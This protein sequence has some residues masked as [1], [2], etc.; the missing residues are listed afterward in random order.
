MNASNNIWLPQGMPCA[1]VIK[2]NT[3]VLSRWQECK[4]EKH[5]LLLNLMPQKEVT[6]LD[7]ARTLQACALSVQ[8]LPM[9]IKGQTY[10]TT[11]LEYMNA[12]YLNFE[13]YEPY[14][15]DHLIITGA[16]L[17]QMPFEQV[18][19]WSQLCNI[20]NW[21]DKHVKHTL[22]ICWGA[23]AGLYKHYGIPKYGLTDKMFG[24]FNQDILVHNSPLMYNMQ[25]TFKM[26]NSRHTEVRATDIK[27]LADNKLD[28]VAMSNE[29]GVG[30]VATKDCSQTYIVGHLEYEPNTLHNE[31]MRDVSKHL[32]IKK[33]LH[34]YDTNGHV[35]YSWKKDAIQFYYNWLNL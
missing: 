18:R 27:T 2:A 15:F 22:Y 10:K 23:Q 33:P 17:E 1:D 19:Y 24:I 11:P 6:E 14:E 20:M 13:E 29:S 16:P 12:F 26:P 31:Y 32:P 25:S 35:V 4:A 7:I 30:V 9:K 3:Y 34:Y 21:A 8:I 5:V 28:I